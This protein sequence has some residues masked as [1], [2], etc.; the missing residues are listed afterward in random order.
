LEHISPDFRNN[1]NIL[2]EERV[3]KMRQIASAL[4]NTM[5]NVEK[6]RHALSP[7]H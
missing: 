2:Q 1:F 6:I 7:W 4:G 3:A 5:P